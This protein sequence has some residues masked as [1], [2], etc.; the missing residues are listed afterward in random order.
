[1][2][3]SV[4]ALASARAERELVD[5][6]RRAGATSPDL[7]TPPPPLRPIA[8]RR[9]R[10]LIDAQAVRPAN[11]GYWLDE[12]I[13]ASYRSDRGA[14]LIALVVALISIAIAIVLAERA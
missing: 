12:T 4:I 11:G 8:E 14:L 9:L 10:R 13:Y 3:A 7:A 5:H 2:S 6:F 1:M